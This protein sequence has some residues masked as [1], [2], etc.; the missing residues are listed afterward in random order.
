M[1][2][3]W[4]D[5][6]ETGAPVHSTQQAGTTIALLLACLRDGFNVKA[7]T[8]IVVTSGVAVATCP[9]HGYSSR[10][11]KSVKIA[12]APVAGL[13]GVKQQTIIDTNSFSYPAPGVA[14]G[15]YTGT[16]D[17][18]RAPLGWEMP[19]HNSNNDVAIFRRLSSESNQQMLRVDDSVVGSLV[20][21]RMI[22]S[23]T[24]VDTY[25][26]LAP[27][28]AQISGGGRWQKGPENANPKAWALFGDGR[29]F[30]LATQQET[31]DKFNLFMFG[32]GVP[33]APG[34]SY[35]TLLTCLDG[36][37]YELYPS[38][39]LSSCEV[40]G[41]GYGANRGGFASRG[42]LPSSVSAERVSLGGPNTVGMPI[43]GQGMQSATTYPF[44]GIAPE[45]H[46]LSAAAYVR[47]EWPGLACPLA[48]LSGTEAL[49]EVVVGDHR[50]V[51]VPTR[52]S[53]LGGCWLMRITGAW[54]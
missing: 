29:A 38:T 17:A 45:L 25:D 31:T 3:I 27:T 49:S 12:G 46:V 41:T 32:D 26:G 8:Q 30:Y 4:Y 28:D 43:G 5:S 18:R 21:V 47:G 11:G 40:Y 52:I 13:N 7:V 51:A 2:P 15:T 20:R 6:S 33:Y 22:E 42:Q 50:Y 44:V 9:N 23:A 36:A 37:S 54:Y 34:D 48:N 39:V 35:F 10:F 24:D 53:S 14:D 19:Y 1:T 16:I